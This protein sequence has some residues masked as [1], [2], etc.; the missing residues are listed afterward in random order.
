MLSL[1]VSPYQIGL[2]L[3]RKYLLGPRTMGSLLCQKSTR[4]T[5]KLDADT[6]SVLP[7]MQGPREDSGYSSDINPGIQLVE[8]IFNYC[9]KLH[10]KTRVMVSGIRR[11]QG[12]HH[13]VINH[14]NIGQMNVCDPGSSGNCASNVSREKAE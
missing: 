2:S 7:H 14:G 5:D 12:L 11:K 4:G 3:H 10:S 1:I 9:S 6:D 13:V 8:R